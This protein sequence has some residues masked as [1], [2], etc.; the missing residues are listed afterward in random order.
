MREVTCGR[1]EGLMIAL[2]IAEKNKR[3]PQRIQAEIGKVLRNVSVEV[4]ANAIENIAIEAEKHQ[5]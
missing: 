5:H 3:S 1:V 2:Q 4:A